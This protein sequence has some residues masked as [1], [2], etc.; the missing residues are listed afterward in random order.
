MSAEFLVDVNVN[1]NFSLHMCI[2]LLNLTIVFMMAAKKRS[3][4]ASECRDKT[5]AAS[6]ELVKKA[7]KMM[8][9]EEV[10]NA[11]LKK[12]SLREF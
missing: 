8:E 5:I 11:F 4:I 7:A 1:D 3:K 12:T 6:V 2:Y 10:K 9:K